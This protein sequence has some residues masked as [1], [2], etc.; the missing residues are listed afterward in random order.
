M[1]RRSYVAIALAIA[2]GG[3]LG[4]AAPMLPALGQRSPTVTCQSRFSTVQSQINERLTGTVG[5]RSLPVAAQSRLANLQSRLVSVQ[6][7]VCERL[8]GGGPQRPGLGNFNC[9]P[10]CPTPP[11]TAGPT[12]APSGPPVPTA[13]TPRENVAV[14][15]NA[16]T[17]ESRS[18]GGD[19]PAVGSKA[20]EPETS[21][22][23]V[24]E[25]PSKAQQSQPSTDSSSAA[26]SDDKAE[27]AA[28]TAST[29]GDDDDAGAAGQR[30]A[31][32]GPSG[33]KH[34]PRC[35][36]GDDDD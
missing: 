27:T 22:S 13:S 16:A 12:A 7:R 23:S 6:S 3:L 20:A 17:H 29:S 34:V 9:P 1:T 19:T 33:S 8:A 5:G 26:S 14:T 21:G 32:T 2:T 25:A 10:G 30:C 15:A 36:G 18:T 31:P 11:P 24:A 35:V 28:D 4:L